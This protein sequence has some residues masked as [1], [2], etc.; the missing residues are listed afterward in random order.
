MHTLDMQQLGWDAAGDWIRSNKG[1]MAMHL[2]NYFASDTQTY[3]GRMFEPLAAMAPRDRFDAYDLAALWSLS[4]TI[5]R[6][7]RDQLLHTRANELNAL[8]RKCWEIIERDPTQQ[9]LQTCDI[10]RLI[11]KGSP[12]VALWQQLLRVDDVGKTKASKL[13]AAKFPGLIPI[14]DGQVSTLL[15]GMKEGAIWRPMH[16]LLTGGDITVADLLADLP[17]EGL[18]EG[19]Q[20]ALREALQQVSVLRRLDVVLWMK[21]QGKSEAA[22]VAPG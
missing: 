7:G 21:A 19:Q 22:E 4:V 5:N 2:F 18:D 20:A 1:T 9:T 12:F 3:L 6:E 10:D 14:W 16:D 17:T 11:A 13:M 8:L 15:G